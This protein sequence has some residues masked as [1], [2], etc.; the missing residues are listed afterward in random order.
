MMK[1]SRLKRE[2]FFGVEKAGRIGL[3]VVLRVSRRTHVST[4]FCHNSIT[5][6]MMN[7]GDGT[8]PMKEITIKIFQNGVFHMT[9]VLHELYDKCSLQ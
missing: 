2:V 7:N 3:S 9:G 8:L 6:V 1:L 5:L 4:G